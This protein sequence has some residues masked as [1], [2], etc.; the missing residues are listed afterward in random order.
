LGLSIEK[1]KSKLAGGFEDFR[2]GIATCDADH[3]SENG[4]IK[5]AHVYIFPYLW[6]QIRLP[7]D[8]ET[9][10][11]V[12][13]IARELVISPVF[14]DET[15]APEDLTY[16]VELDRFQ[17]DQEAGGSVNSRTV[18]NQEPCIYP[19]VSPGDYWLRVRH[20][21][22]V[23]ED[24]RRITIKND[25]EVIRPRLRK[26]S[27]LVIPVEWPELSDPESLPVEIGRNFIRDDGDRHRSLQS[28][29]KLK[30]DCIVNEQTYIATPEAAKGRFRNSVIFPY[31][32]P[33]KY[34]VE[35]PARTIEPDG[36]HPGCVIEP[37]SIDVEIRE[38][39]PTFVITGSL[40]IRYTENR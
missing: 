27:S 18:K 36:V 17:E 21:G 31:L 25:N 12:D 19:N 39:S 7:V 9:V 6:S 5:R 26:G 23:L 22:A 32:P 38:D 34:T 1:E 3:F 10:G 28:V 20:P 29:V 15:G 33:G 35:S 2:D 13:I 4:E 40:K 30:G 11:T 37:T 16:A 14:P 24:R 8:H